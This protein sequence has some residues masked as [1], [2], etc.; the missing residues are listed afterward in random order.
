MIKYQGI[1]PEVIILLVLITISLDLCIDIVQ[2]ELMLVTLGTYRVTLLSCCHNNIVDRYQ[3]L[4]K[5]NVTIDV[6]LLQMWPCYGTM[7]TSDMYGLEA[8]T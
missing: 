8:A 1:F 6:K 7:L 3:V 2:R 5:I 4:Q